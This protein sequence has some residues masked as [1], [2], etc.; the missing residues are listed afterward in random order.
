MKGQGDFPAAVSLCLIVARGPKVW[1]GKRTILNFRNDQFSIWN[2]TAASANPAVV[3][4]E[5][6]PFGGMWSIIWGVI[7]VP[8]ISCRWVVIIVD[9]FMASEGFYHLKRP[10]WAYLVSEPTISSRWVVI[11]LDGFIYHMKRNFR[12]SYLLSVGC[13]RPR[14]AYLGCFKVHLLNLDLVLRE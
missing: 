3:S 4:F 5:Y 1:N 13:D 12:A 14:C 2:E 8:P 9:G 11:I 6:S 10:R 7:S